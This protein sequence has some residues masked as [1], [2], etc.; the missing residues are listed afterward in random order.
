MPRIT[1]E[2]LRRVQDASD[3]I[4]IA[5]SYGLKLRRV[6]SNFSALCPFHKEKTPS[7]NLN[8][9]LQI[10]K[11]FGCGEAGGVIKFVEKMEHC[12]FVEAVEQLAQR[13]GI[14]L[15]YDGGGLPATGT[16][17][18]ADGKKPL[19]W[20]NQIAYT[21]FRRAFADPEEGARAREYLRGRG[22]SENTINAWGLGWAPD[23]WDGLVNFCTDEVRKHG[24]ESKVGKAIKFGITAGIFRFNE[25]KQR[26]YDAFR[27][28]VM[29]TIFDNQ[30][31]PIAFGGR[32][33]EEKPD[34]GGKYLN[35]SETPLF[36]K[37]KTLFGLNYAAR[38]IS[39]ART[40]I[41]VE[42]YVDT[43]MCHQYGIR[44]V[45]A[46]LGTSL[47]PEHVRLLR[48]YIGPDGKVVALFDADKAGRLA[49]SRAIEI[50]MAEDVALS[51]LQGLEVKDAGEFLPKFGADKFREFLN[52]AK[53]CFTYV[54]EEHLG[55][56]FGND[57]AGKTA[58]VMKVME[59]VNLCPN[60]IRRQMMRQK[61]AEITGIDE[62]LLPEPEAKRP[63]RTADAYRRPGAPEPARA[64]LPAGMPVLEPERRRQ[65]QSERLLLRYMAAE[66]AW[67]DYII[68]LFPP[69][70]WHFD[71]MHQVAVLIRDSWQHGQKPDLS[72]F[73]LQ[74][75]DE[76]VRAVL[77]DLVSP[78]EEPELSEAEMKFLLDRIARGELLHRQR[79]AEE[80]LAQAELN[81]DLEAENAAL[82][83]LQ[84]IARK[85]RGRK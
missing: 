68:D 82:A 60:A 69:D 55:K 1:E 48:R 71:D 26:T 79:N 47:T 58:A 61:V 7:F 65:R 30:N 28:R 29:F 20:A 4:S 74:T 25:E 38:E 34:S 9:Q 14:T 59:I 45:V 52:G 37:R 6:G 83:E 78:G 57:L 8:P 64:E 18:R 50:F 44:N 70:D 54:L 21:Y 11:C 12:E 22:F 85:L 42:G 63:G 72:V 77:I 40:A 5:E 80:R 24:D 67:C 35:T 84:E 2:C 76:D 62:K 53:D 23:S 10:F 15:E 19:Y 73:L 49:T 17:A 81:Q 36:E 75:V 31:R 56:N 33:F 32:V 16:A 66:K 41:I 39:A 13:A 43:I 3:I 46:T 27:G 51:V